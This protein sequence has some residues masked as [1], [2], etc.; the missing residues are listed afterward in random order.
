MFNCSV[1]TSCLG[2]NGTPLIQ[3][4]FLIIKRDNIIL[5]HQI[6]NESKIHHL[7]YQI[8]KLHNPRI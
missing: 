2:A 4:I 1:L 7:K 5:K 3:L 6:Q 8:S